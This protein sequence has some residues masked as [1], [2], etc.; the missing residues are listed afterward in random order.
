[1]IEIVLTQDG[2]VLWRINKFGHR[3]LQVALLVTDEDM[4]APGKTSSLLEKWR[5]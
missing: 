2:G 3:V 1:M 5:D 4:H